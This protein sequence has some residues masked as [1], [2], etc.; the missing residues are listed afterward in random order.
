MGG[1]EPQANTTFVPGFQ[2]Y[3]SYFGRTATKLNPCE[4]KPQPKLSGPGWGNV[5]TIDAAWLAM[6]AKAPGARC[7]M[8][9]LSV[10]VSGRAH[11]L[12]SFSSLALGQ[13]LLVVSWLW[14]GV[15]GCGTRCERRKNA[16][17]EADATPS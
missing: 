15:V 6:Q 3:A 16:S 4:A 7:Y 1:Y 12:N 13:G 14:L 11:F 17:Q 5:N 8:R 9:E 10:H 2:A